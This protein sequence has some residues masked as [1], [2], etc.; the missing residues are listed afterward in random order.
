MTLGLIAL[1]TTF[2]CGPS[3]DLFAE[4]GRE[5]WTA[6]RV[7][8][9]PDL[10]SPYA[11]EVAF[12]GL[13]FQN[14]AV[15]DKVPGTNLLIIG[16]LAGRLLTFPED[17]KADSP[18]TALE[19]KKVHP[20]MGSLYGLAFHPKFAE[21]RQV[22]LCYTMGDNKPDGTRVSRWT[23]TK[24]DPPR[25]D[26]ESE[27][28]IYSWLSGGHNGGCLAFGPDGYLYIST[29]DGAGPFPPDTL[30][31]GQD[32]SR[33]LSKV[34]RIDVD[35]EEG[36][37]AYRIPPDNPF[38]AVSGAIPETWAFGFRNPWKMT[39]DDATGDLW[40][41]DVG[42]ELWELVY[43]VERG[44]NYGWSITEGRQP[45]RKDLKPGPT[46]IRPPIVDHPHSEAGSITGGFVYRGDRLPDLAGAYIYGDWLTGTLWGLRYD[47]Q[48]KRVTWRAELAKTPVQIVTFGLGHR[49]ELY[50]VD[51]ERSR[52]I[53]R[54]VPNQAAPADASFP[55]R[56]SETGLFASAKEQAPEKGVIP[57]QVNA[58]IWADGASS[59]RWLAIPGRG[60]LGWDEAKPWKAP[61]GTVLAKTIAF[62]G[63]RI[64]TQLLH[65]ED[66]TWRP[67]SYVWNPEQTDATLAPAEGTSVEIPLEGG[68]TRPHRI[69]SRSECMICHNP[70]TAG[71]AP[72]GRQSAP[73]LAFDTPQL[74][75][76]DQLA[77]WQD[78][79]WL[80]RPLPRSTAELPKGIDC[81]EESAPL[82]VRARNYL[83]LHCAACHRF[84]GG[85][86]AK[87][88]LSRE[89]PLDQTNLLEAPIQGGFGLDEPKVVAPGLPEASVL[90][91]RMAKLGAG[92]MPRIGSSQVDEKGL[93]LIRRWIES[94][95]DSPSRP[96]VE[97]LGRID[98]PSG[99]GC[100]QAVRELCGTTRGALAVVRWAD[101]EPR[102]RPMILKVIREQNRPDLAELFERFLP[103]SARARR[104]GDAIDVDALLALSGDAGRG[105]ALFLESPTLSCRNCHAHKGIGRTVGPDLGR[106][107]S[108]Y[109]KAEILEHIL[110]PSKA[111][112]EEYRVQTVET[113]D[114][115]LV[116]GLV[117]RRTGTEL[118]LR[119]AEGKS[120]VI[121]T[122]EIE[123]SSISAQS[124]MPEGAL[125]DM[126]AQEVADLL[127]FLESL[128]GS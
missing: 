77:H 124:L 81:H 30:N 100:E 103:E 65:F 67:Y 73:P 44:G 96:E 63:R 5:S 110:K 45:A 23:M 19:I 117:V 37:R 84:Q 55:T 83:H 8:G 121:P 52:K 93:E 61:E 28:V 57:Y 125:R 76:G 72:A 87:L 4:D 1:G 79:G 10:P 119:D 60:R 90:Y 48:A 22:F 29:G 115:R 82:D 94:L 13:T 53:Y 111:I 33:P 6:S 116:N 112:D 56:L 7:R 69:S 114:G 91:L 38:I 58:T 105:E 102:A 35:H 20:E 126:T 41:G 62:G 127:A 59:E 46:P 85:G 99:N 36:D 43:R 95:D 12:P 89:T 64:E 122:S 128:K 113:K 17:P 24:D 2:I 74:N 97:R 70:W 78:G 68:G 101:R 21:N 66:G 31:A 50:F 49:G 92:H 98:D 109:P 14:P 88:I 27:R 39:F 25:I 18:A 106:I 120:V 15:M 54:L 80:D 11:A 108:K 86:A 34:L 9:T 75:K 71:D 16:E 104:L 32:M 47:A 107:G 40:L 51:Y 42:W 3:N 123:Q 118:E 26:P